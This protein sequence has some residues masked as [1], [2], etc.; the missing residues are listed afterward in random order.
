MKKNLIFNGKKGQEEMVG[1]VL[2]II[3][4]SV[5]LLFFL[6]F[7]LQDRGGEIESQE[8]ESF[9]QSFLPYTTD[10]KSGGKNLS[11]RKLLFECVEERACLDDREMCDVLNKTLKGII[12]SSWQVG[13]QSQY[14][15]YRFKITLN[16]EEMIS[17]GEDNVT[18][19]YKGSLQNFAKGSDSVDIIFRVYS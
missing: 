15:G 4:V 12:D 19:S 8:V 17:F 1:F 16:G 18:S 3:V 6:G 5:I 11:I 13:S 14:K 2:I 7:V 10:C 9:I